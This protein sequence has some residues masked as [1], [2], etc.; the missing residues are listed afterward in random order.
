MANNLQNENETG[1]RA[2]QLVPVRCE[3][4]GTGIYKDVFFG[5][6]QCIVLSC[7]E[8]MSIDLRDDR[9]SRPPDNCCR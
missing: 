5:K 8:A 4:G 7:T 3:L 9:F 6:G 2:E 1:Y